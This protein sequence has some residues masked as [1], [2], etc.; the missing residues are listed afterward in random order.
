MLDSAVP[1]RWVRKLCQRKSGRTA[2]KYDV[3]FFSPEGRNFRSRRELAAC[4]PVTHSGLT[5][6]L[7]ATRLG[8]PPVLGVQA[9]IVVL[10][11]AARSCQR[12]SLHY[13][14]VTK[15]QPAAFRRRVIG[16]TMDLL[17]PPL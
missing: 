8:P 5:S 7:R 2:G 9:L 15:P 11:A 3:H 13:R 12:G 4:L 14:E 10:L 6:L 16:L 17:R 1:E